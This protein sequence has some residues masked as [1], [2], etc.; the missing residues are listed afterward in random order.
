[1]DD[2]KPLIYLGLWLTVPIV[3]KN[4]KK[5]FSMLCTGSEG[6]FLSSKHLLFSHL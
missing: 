3:P 6:Q 1:M 4:F 2:L 5:Y